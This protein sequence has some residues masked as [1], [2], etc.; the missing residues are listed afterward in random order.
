LSRPARTEAVPTDRV[1]AIDGPSGAGKSTV[2]RALARRLGFGY[3]DTGAMYRAVALWFVRHG[4]FTAAGSALEPSSPRAQATERLLDKLAL[5]LPPGEPQQVLV[6]GEDVA[7]ELRS[8]RIEALVSEVAS[9]PLVRARMRE[10]QRRIARQGP[11]VA[12]GRDMTSV[13]FPHARWQFYLDADPAERARR[14]LAEFRARGIETDQTQVRTEIERRDE[15][16]SNRADA[17][18]QRLP[19]VRYVDTTH[20]SAAEVVERL[21]ALVGADLADCRHGG[22]A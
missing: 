19:H 8:P 11:V 18:L 1:V 12:E 5:E 17:P 7:A 13:V 14:R 9:V 20:L 22:G 16:D 6:D 15:L 10:L 3:L 2:A 4:W 21:A